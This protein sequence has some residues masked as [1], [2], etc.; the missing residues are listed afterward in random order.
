[1]KFPPL[2]L[3]NYTEIDGILRRFQMD[4]AE[5][6]HEKTLGTLRKCSQHPCL[7]SHLHV[8]D[9]GTCQTFP[10]KRTVHLRD[11]PDFGNIVFE[12]GSFERVTHPTEIKS[13]CE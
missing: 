9:R 2:R 1:M 6:D 3:P 11:Y 12:Q 7:G 4:Y 10:K 8:F 13:K 5:P